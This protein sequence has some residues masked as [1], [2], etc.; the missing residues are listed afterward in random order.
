MLLSIDQDAQGP[1]R[2]YALAYQSAQPSAHAYRE[3]W[4]GL[5]RPPRQPPHIPRPHRLEFESL[6][7]AL[8]QGPGPY[9][10][11]GILHRLE[12]ERLPLDCA[13]AHLGITVFCVVRVRVPHK[14]ALNG[15]ILS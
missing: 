10:R 9:A 7:F 6:P 3:V 13:S 8:W 1:G 2:R 15:L 11:P 14:P 5:L 4:S 12:C